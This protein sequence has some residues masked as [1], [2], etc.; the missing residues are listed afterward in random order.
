MRD[1]RAEI[2]AINGADH[3]DKMLRGVDRYGKPRAPLARS[4]MEKIRHGKRGPGPSLIPNVWTSRYLTT[5]AQRWVW[6]EGRSELSSRFDGFVSKGGFPIPMAHEMG[7]PRRSLPRRAIMGITP[8]GWARVTRA[9]DAFA[10]RV[11]GPE[12]GVGGL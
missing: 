2:M 5:F 11:F 6:R 10:E 4:T 12:V 8:M 7:V 1:L 9:F 3:I